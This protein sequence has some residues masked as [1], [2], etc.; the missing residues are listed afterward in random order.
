MLDKLNEKIDSQI[1]RK[2]EKDIRNLKNITDKINII[3]K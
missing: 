3:E 2:D 1:C